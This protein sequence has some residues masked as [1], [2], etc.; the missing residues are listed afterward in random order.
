LIVSCLF[1][2]LPAS[3]AQT[4][5]ENVDGRWRSILGLQKGDGPYQWFAYPADNFGVMTFYAPSSGKPLTDADRI[6]ATWTCI[7]VGPSAIPTDESRFTSVKGFAN[8]SLRSSFELTNDKQGRAAMTLLLSNLF[9]VLGIDGPV[10][11][12]RT[13]TFDLRVSQVYMRSI[14]LPKFQEFLKSNDLVRDA[15]NHGELTCIGADIVARGL[16]LMIEIDPKQDPSINAQ[17]TQAMGKLGRE[18]MPEVKISNPWQGGY[19]VQF[20]GFLV[21]ATQ[22]E[23]WPNPGAT[24]GNRSSSNRQR[25]TAS[26]STVPLPRMVPQIFQVSPRK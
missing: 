21:L 15:A 25:L 4:Y 11:L 13:V 2:S 18:G 19:L 23:R 3:Q 22:M 14:D 17:L 10:S 7:G 24:A 9:K 6:C 16:K 5:G 20:P 12:S 8:S 1:Y 26:A